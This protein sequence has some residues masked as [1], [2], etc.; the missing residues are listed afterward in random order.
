[1]DV[2]DFSISQHSSYASMEVDL[3]SVFSFTDFRQALDVFCFGIG[4]VEER[5]HFWEELQNL[6]LREF[7][8]APRNRIGKLGRRVEATLNSSQFTVSEESCIFTE[9]RSPCSCRK[10]PDIIE[11]FSKRPHKTRPDFETLHFPPKKQIT[12]W[13]KQISFAVLQHKQQKARGQ[14]TRKRVEQFSDKHRPLKMPKP[15]RTP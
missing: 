14:R 10:L 13:T 7:V 2:F 8:W 3:V 9:D 12:D 11:H 4:P 15:H 1:M 6:W 5:Y